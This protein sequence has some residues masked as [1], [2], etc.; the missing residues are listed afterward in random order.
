MSNAHIH[1]GLHLRSWGVTG[2]EPYTVNVMENI[3]P[4][5]SLFMTAYSVLPRSGDDHAGDV[6][7]LP[8]PPLLSPP[9]PLRPFLPFS[10]PFLPRPLPPFRS[11]TQLIQ[12]GGLGSGAAAEPQPKSNLVHFSLKMWHLVARF[13]SIF[14]G[15]N[16]PLLVIP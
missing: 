14:L 6:P 13:Q 8:P 9:L 11:R 1:V 12:L 10:Q 15:I 16:W 4:A 2:G 5:C 3:L 7:S